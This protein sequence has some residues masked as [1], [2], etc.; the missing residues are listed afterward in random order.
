[1]KCASMF[2]SSPESRPSTIV[3]SC[4]HWRKVRATCAGLAVAAVLFGSGTTANA[5]EL[6]IDP[7]FDVRLT[8]GILYGTGTVSFFGFVFEKDLLLDLYEPMGPNVP[9][10][11]PGI[12]LLHGGFGPGPFAS[13][14]APGGTAT[15]V[16]EQLAARGYVAVSIDRRLLP[17][18]PIVAGDYDELIAVAVAAGG[19]LE[20]TRVAATA[21]AW[22]IPCLMHC[23][24]DLGL[25]TA[26][27]L[28]IAASTPNFSGPNDTCY[29]GLVD[30]II[31]DPF[32]IESG[33]IRLPDAPGLGVEVDEKKLE[34]YS[35]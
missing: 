32:K 7:Q 6:F 20:V 3:G 29:H 23:S 27:I 13:R 24:H 22:G 19:I 26:A 9:D 4:P 14:N 8:E 2:P 30:D 33:R 21:A 35:V 10:S 34:R 17:A 11:L 25:K 12:V 31:K 15:V 28:H 16:A 5:Q 18:S 1:M